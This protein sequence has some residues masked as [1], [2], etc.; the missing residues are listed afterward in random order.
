MRTIVLQICLAALFGIPAFTTAGY[1]LPDA[2]S[3]P[4]SHVDRVLVYKSKRLMELRN[5]SEVIRSYRVALGRNPVGRKVRAGDCRTPEGI[6]RLDRRSAAS[7][8]YRSIHISYPNAADRAAARKLGV[9]PGGD[10]MIHGLPKGFE[11]LE[12]WH[13]ITDWTK[14]CIAVTNAEISEVWR[15]V[16]DGTPIEIKP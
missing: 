9:A 14:G 7:R 3:A 2:G 4:H 8:F 11:D 15:L 16:P 6:Y 12:E 10:I 1:C 5:G 13:V